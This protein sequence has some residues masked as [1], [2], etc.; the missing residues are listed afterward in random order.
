MKREY[1]VVI[2]FLLFIQLYLEPFAAAFEQYT[3]LVK[4]DSCILDVKA[5]SPEISR[6]LPVQ[7]GEKGFTIMVNGYKIELTFIMERCRLRGVMEEASGR[8]FTVYEQLGIYKVNIDLGYSAVLSPMLEKPDAYIIVKESVTGCIESVE[9]GSD[10]SY[11]SRALRNGEAFVMG[12]FYRGDTVVIA[13]RTAESCKLV[14]IEAPTGF[15]SSDRLILMIRGNVTVTARFIEIKAQAPEATGEELPP[16]HQ[17]PMPDNQ[18]LIILLILSASL[19]SVIM[20]VRGRRGRTYTLDEA[21]S[22]L[23]ELSRESI[24][25]AVY[26]SGIPFAKRLSWSAWSTYYNQFLNQAGPLLQRLELLPED[27]KAVLQIHLAAAGIVPVSDYWRERATEACIRS[28]RLISS[29]RSLAIEELKRFV[30]LMRRDPREAEAFSRLGRELSEPPRAVLHL[31]NSCNAEI[32]EPF[33]VADTAVEPGLVPLRE[34]RIEPVGESLQKQPPKPAQAINQIKGHSPILIEKPSQ[35]VVTASRPERAERVSISTPEE[36]IEA[37]KRYT[38]FELGPKTY[39]FWGRAL[40][41]L[42]E[43]GNDE[44]IVRLAG[45]ARGSKMVE[46]EEVLG[47]GVYYPVGWCE[48]A[49]VLIDRE[50]LACSLGA[51]LG[52]PVYPEQGQREHPSDAVLIDTGSIERLRTVGLRRISTYSATRA[53]EVAN[54]LGIKRIVAVKCLEE[55]IAGLVLQRI[56]ERAAEL[57]TPRPILVRAAIGATLI[58]SS[59]LKILDAWDAPEQLQDNRCHRL[60]KLLQ[61]V[62]TSVKVLIGTSEV[63]APKKLRARLLVEV[64]GKASR[65]ADLMLMEGYEPPDIDKPYIVKEVEKSWLELQVSEEPGKPVYV[66]KINS[67]PKSPT[68]VCLGEGLFFTPPMIPVRGAKAVPVEEARGGGHIDAVTYAKWGSSINVSKD[69]VLRSMI[70]LLRGRR[71]LGIG[72]LR[73]GESGDVER[74]KKSGINVEHFHIDPEAVRRRVLR[75]FGS[76][77]EGRINALVNLLMVF[78]ALPLVAG[79]KNGDLA[80]R[81]RDGLKDMLSGRESFQFIAEA[82]HQLLTKG[83]VETEG[84]SYAQRRILEWL[85][86]TQGA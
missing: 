31:I 79:E 47:E 12:P 17:G 73:S 69:D 13:V 34:S 7:R 50:H 84:L 55:R 86:L 9:Y 36:L 14:G 37:L 8:V 38:Y 2:L 49:T 59:G 35:E 45:V 10:L 19:A 83:R 53:F 18:L 6:P 5:F 78:P 46:D 39:R 66:V 21:L 81:M 63:Q 74:L 76:L 70:E 22:R 28:A 57:E 48:I 16:K 64:G 62:I 44:L 15:V 77:S 60:G 3:V 68:F 32:G 80:D 67:L 51:T 23:A 85:G 72:F 11:M 42:L 27:V 26:S 29:D 82:L 24:L 25:A 33:S 71:L 52:R 56:S 4:G 1:M 30:R 54:A 75:E 65:L 61:S 43:E 20:V 58:L 40:L 41:K